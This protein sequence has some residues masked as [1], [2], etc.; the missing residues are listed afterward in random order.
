MAWLRTLRCTV[1]R[2]RSAWESTDAVC[3]EGG[4]NFL[5][6]SQNKPPCDRLLF[7]QQHYICGGRRRNLLLLE[8]W[9]PRSVKMAR[10]TLHRLALLSN[11]PVLLHFADVIGGEEDLAIVIADVRGHG[12]DG[13]SRVDGKFSER[14]HIA[15]Y[16]DDKL[17]HTISHGVRRLVIVNRLL[18]ALQPPP[19]LGQVELSVWL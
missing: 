4:L 5:K 16:G 19:Q 8:S 13:F 12:A 9:R 2:P 10:S 11:R 17:V 15:S 6:R 14:L 7:E 18:R 1:G 3:W